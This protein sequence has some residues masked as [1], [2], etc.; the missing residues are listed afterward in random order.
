MRITK[1]ER[2]MGA[3]GC[4]KHNKMLDLDFNDHFHIRIK[5]DS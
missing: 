3:W 4:I 5:I 2:R 1:K